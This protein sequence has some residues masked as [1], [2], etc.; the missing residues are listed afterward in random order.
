MPS[1]VAVLSAPPVAAAAVHVAKFVGR[2]ILSVAKAA[3]TG[4]KS[5]LGRCGSTGAL[6]T[7]SLSR[8]GTQV[9][10]AVRAVAKHPMMQPV[11][12]A[13]QATLFLV[14]PVSSGVVAHRLLQGHDSSPVV[15]SRHRALPCALPY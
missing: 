9:A 2:G 10:D 1:V 8:T 11:V 13:V 14:H 4:I 15:E 5:L 12:K 6:I 3:W 7:E